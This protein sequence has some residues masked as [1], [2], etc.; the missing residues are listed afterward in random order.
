MVPCFECLSLRHLRLSPIDIMGKDGRA[1]GAG[2]SSVAAFSL[3]VRR[4]RGRVS[5]EKVN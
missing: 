4:L 2:I 5:V 1:R 3:T